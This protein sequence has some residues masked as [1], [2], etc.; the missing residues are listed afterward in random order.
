LFIF[1]YAVCFSNL[2]A[3]GKGLAKAGISSTKAQIITKALFYSKSLIKHFCPACAKPM[4]VAG[5]FDL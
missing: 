1:Y 5:F 3:N 2:S 4:L